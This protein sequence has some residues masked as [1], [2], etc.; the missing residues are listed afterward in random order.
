MPMEQEQATDVLE[1]LVGSWRPSLVRYAFRLTKCRETAEDLSQEA[2]MALYVDLQHGKKI[3]NL[4]AWTVVIVRNLAYRD[5]RNRRSRGEVLEST[6]T[7][8]ARSGPVVY[9][10]DRWER[11]KELFSVLTP[12]E[13]EVMMLRVHVLKYREIADQLKISP[14]S[15]AT[16]LARGLRKMH[17]ASQEQFGD[18]G[19]IKRT[20]AMGDETSSSMGV[21]QFHRPEVAG[22]VNAKDH[23]L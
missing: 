14:K 21:Q 18:R 7:L 1:S 3:S 13:A 8:D 4:K 6:D 23:R 17:V 20:S 9:E 11:V 19:S 2:F 10:D 15:V 16:L 22:W 5:H 12:R